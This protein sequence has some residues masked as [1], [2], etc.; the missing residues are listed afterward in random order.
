VTGD[1]MSSQIKHLRHSKYG[2][3]FTAGS[4]IEI[5]REPEEEN[6]NILD[7]EEEYEISE[8]DMEKIKSSTGIND[9]EKILG[10][11]M[12]IGSVDPDEIIDALNKK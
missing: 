6:E 10:K 7:K 12:E 4:R 9:D 2:R 5:D 1:G 8:E 3:A 11:V